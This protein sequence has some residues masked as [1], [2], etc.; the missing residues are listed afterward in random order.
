[1]TTYGWKGS[2]CLV[3]W[4]TEQEIHLWKKLEEF[5]SFDLQSCDRHIGSS[6][7]IHKNKINWTR[8][9]HAP[10][11]AL[12]GK[13]KRGNGTAGYPNNEWQD[14]GADEATVSEKVNNE[15]MHCKSNRQ[16]RIMIKWVSSFRP[17]EAHVWV[18][19][20]LSAC[21]QNGLPLPHGQ[22]G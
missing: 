21:H 16:V 22:A 17:Y 1:M 11:M 12:S 4:W 19:P 14:H 2:P 7:N 15:P 20:S 5:S 10:A 8:N 3:S 13:L 9:C 18:S 6:L